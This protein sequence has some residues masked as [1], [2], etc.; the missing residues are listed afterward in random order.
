MLNANKYS[1]SGT[2]TISGGGATPGAVSLL[3]SPDGSTTTPDATTGN[4][5]FTNL[6]SGNYTVTA[7]LAGYASYTSNPISVQS[8]NVT[9]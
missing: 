3:L 5:A 7:I 1:I 9:G 2:V 6:S 8:A 4:Y